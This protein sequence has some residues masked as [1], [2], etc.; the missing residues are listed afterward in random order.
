MRIGEVARATG[1]SPRLLRYYEER[2]LLRP[3]RSKSDQR[4]YDDG[5]IQ[6][7]QQIRDLLAA[8]LSTER[9]FELLPCFDAPAHERTSHL[10]ESLHAERTKID[11][12]VASL[13][14]AANAL[15]EIIADVVRVDTAT[16]NDHAGASTH[17]SP[18]EAA[19]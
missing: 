1:V 8:G 17:H 13:V 16:G 19:G 15:D 10:L 3:V 7:V 4:I 18:A 5:A 9:I 2:G 6:R 12:A 14:T 11:V